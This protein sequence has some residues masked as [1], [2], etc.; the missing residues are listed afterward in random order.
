MQ[1]YFFGH[2]KKAF[3][4]SSAKCI[5]RKRSSARKP[6]ISVCKCGNTKIMLS[7]HQSRSMYTLVNL[8]MVKYFI[9]LYPPYEYQEGK[10]KKK[11][12]VVNWNL[13]QLSV[14]FESTLVFDLIIHSTHR[15]ISR[16]ICDRVVQMIEH[17]S[18][19]D[20]HWKKSFF[21]IFC[22]IIVIIIFTVC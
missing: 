5:I 20:D 13:F 9:I 21:L 19:E 16:W 3:L 7:Q 17:V 10:G 11:C 22:I 14:S 6:G 8:K 2:F 4:L 12:K 18:D 1:V 15:N